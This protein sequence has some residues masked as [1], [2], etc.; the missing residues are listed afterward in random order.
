MQTPIIVYNH[1]EYKD[2]PSELYTKEKYRLQVELL[3]MQEWTIKEK[4]KVAIVLEGRDAAGKGSTIKRFIQ[5][6]MPKITRVVELGVPTSKQ[7]RNWF[8]TYNK[9]L[10]RDGEIAFFDRSWYSRAVIQPTMGYCSKNQYY[11]FINNVNDWEKKLIDDGLILF[12]FYLS[13]SQETQKYRF[14]LRQ[15]S[16]LK[17]WKVTDNDLKAM[18][19][20]HLYTRYKEQMFE[21]TSTEHA[22]W[23][24]INSDNK[25]IARLN[26]MRYVLKRT[27]YSGKKKVKAKRYFKELEDFQITIKGV[28]F[29]NLTKEQ[30][31]LL[32]KIKAHE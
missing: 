6:M 9:H 8:N 27:N 1:T 23:I 25:M 18:E 21:Q 29:E 14:F 26:T 3:K 4:K 7:N 11:Y 5:H 17:Y 13:V 31:E 24:L 30:Y 20:W 22:P 2:L 28:K 15:S 16:E 19:H 12:K 32:F 10:P